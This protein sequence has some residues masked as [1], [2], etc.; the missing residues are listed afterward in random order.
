MTE[1]PSPDE[2][3]AQVR[4]EE[5]RAKRGKLTIFFGAAPGVGKTYA[6]LEAARTAAEEGKEVV[7]GIAEAHGRY[8]TA[9]LLLGMEILPRRKV[10]YRA[11]VLDELDVDAALA[12][13]PTLLIVDEL[14]HTNA[15]GSRHA[16]RWQD[17][18]EIL[19]AGID[20]YTTLNVQHV[21]T[22]KDT[23]AQITGIQVRETV[24]DSVLEMA[25]EIRVVDLPPD[26]LLQRLREGKVYVPT[27]AARAIDNFFR[28]GNLIALRELA[29]RIT[30][31]R[32]DEQMQ[33]YKRAHRIP[34]VWPARERILVCVSPS[35]LSAR[36]VRVARRM[37]SALG[38][39]WLAVWVDVG[40]GRTS[41]NAMARVTEHLRLAE[42]LGAETVV[43]HAEHPAERLVRYAR[44]RNVTRIVVGKPT[45][46]RWR[47][48][49]EGSFLD[50]IVRRSGE[51][52][53]L[54]IS[55]TGEPLERRP[56][57]RAS[58]RAPLAVAALWA[59]VV[60]AVATLVC[61]MM[62]RRFE[63]ADLVMVYLLGVVV[64]STRFGLRAALIAVV[65][66]IAA[67]DFFFVPPH[68]TFAVADLEHAVTFAVMF[69]VGS[70][71]GGLTDRLRLQRVL[72]ERREGRTAA[73]YAFTR[74]LGTARDRAEIVALAAA[75]FRDVLDARIAVFVP[76]ETGALVVVGTP[77]FEIDDRERSVAAWS[78]GHGLAAGRGTDTLPGARATYL[79][80]AGSQDGGGVLGVARRESPLLADPEQK[81]LVEMFA[82]QLAAA[83]ERAFLAERA[84]R[85]QVETEAER[86]RNALLSSV[87]HDLR[88]PLAVIEGAATALLDPTA[89]IGAANRTELVQTIADEATRLGR[90]V[91]D[92]LDVTRLESGAV[93]VHRE[94]QPIDDVVG[95]A[96]IRLEPELRGRPIEVAIPTDLP[97]VPLDEVLVEQALVNL[98]ENAIKYTSAGSPLTIRARSLA[99]AVEVELADRGPGLP[100][101][102]E[103]RIFEKF[104]RSG[105]PSAT[106]GAGLGLAI[107]R[108]IVQAH[109]GRIFAENR[110]GGGA[111]FRFTL[112]I[113]GEPPAVDQTGTLH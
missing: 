56:P 34:A 11:I 25:D 60:T 97:L 29:L 35:P 27:E 55:S 76:D 13:R 106:R 64:V 17:V 18:E 92:L 20:V 96:L 24:P 100:L 65:L 38:A 101:G 99:G 59:A 15:P 74:Q 98:L 82:S 61:A 47:D 62:V 39:D 112:P 57:E 104:F 90:L 71:V 87:S 108:A 83:L 9:S 12:R 40:G 16:K 19:H 111:V 113:V 53:V 70:V 48:L 2:I 22:L 84:Q 93:S 79:P 80:L 4:E 23:V 1:R 45:H 75:R 91:R 32:V 42:Q 43:L 54:V 73:L 103:E 5:E 86:M 78:F 3:L 14:A 105:E 10:P 36:L 28:K 33:R 58:L 63:L 41:A 107:A 66:G 21:E 85:A 7:V 26:E 50:E 72:A 89:P 68:G 37:A 77:D 95:A 67:L 81:H 31:E 44:E 46:S 8:E 52:D 109:G 49:V 6:M 110:E 51:I 88:T 94:W 102:H 69:T 30:A